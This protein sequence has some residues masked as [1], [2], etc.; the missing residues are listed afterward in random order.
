VAQ[1]QMKPGYVEEQLQDMGWGP[2]VS[3]GELL[4][5]IFDDPEQF[6]KGEQKADGRFMPDGRSPWLD[7]KVLK[8]AKAL[9]TENPKL[10]INA[11]M[12]QAMKALKWPTGGP[13][14]LG[15]IGTPSNP[16]GGFKTKTFSGEEAVLFGESLS[17]ANE[18]LDRKQ[19]TFR[20]RPEQNTIWWWEHPSEEVRDETAAKLKAPA[21]VRHKRIFGLYDKESFNPAHFMP[22]AEKA[23]E[24][25]KP[26]LAG[27]GKQAFSGSLGDRGDLRDVKMATLPG[28]G[29]QRLSGVALENRTEKP[30]SGAKLMPSDGELEKRMASLQETVSAGNPAKLK[31]AWN[32]ATDMTP[33][34]SSDQEPLLF[35][36]YM[37]DPDMKK[38]SASFYAI[39]PNTEA[40]RAHPKTRALVRGSAKGLGLV[41][42]ELTE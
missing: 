11:A 19:F 25:P 10:E 41:I 2:E 37:S 29:L 17:H 1:K 15:G 12:V 39:A 28:K 9:Q 13:L 42:K 7:N 18:G 20:Y 8:K 6:Y 26:A 31:E 36:V 24:G 3:Q 38:D 5:D 33:E 23:E 32:K 4:T 34:D 22:D 40:V 14:V 16:L 35:M 21:S 30:L 27:L